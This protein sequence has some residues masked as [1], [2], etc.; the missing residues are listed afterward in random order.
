MALLVFENVAYRVTDNRKLSRLSQQREIGH[1]WQLFDALL[2]RADDYHIK[3]NRDA[4][5]TV[6]GYQKLGLSC[7]PE[8]EVVFYYS[9][10]LL[11]RSPQSFQFY[12]RRRTLLSVFAGFVLDACLFQEVV[13][14]FEVYACG[15]TRAQGPQS[16]ICMYQPQP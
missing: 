6:I 15:R 13:Y 12:E 1:D 2:E 11:S 5:E 16:N 7:R 14:L 10:L 8:R 9:F 4:D 3:G